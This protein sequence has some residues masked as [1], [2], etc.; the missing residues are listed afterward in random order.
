[1]VLP[2]AVH[3]ETVAIPTS[4]WYRASG[5]NVVGAYV[6]TIHINDGPDKSSACIYLVRNCQH[7]QYLGNVS[8][9]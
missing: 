2:S 7:G 6:E 9:Y 3:L 8:Y 5:I 4:L 1:M